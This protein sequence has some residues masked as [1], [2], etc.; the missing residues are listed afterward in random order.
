MR[1]PPGLPPRLPPLG[2]SARL[3]ALLLGG[4][5]LTLLLIGGLLFWRVRDFGDAQARQLALG[6]LSLIARSAQAEGDAPTRLYAAYQDLAATALASG[7]WGVLVLAAPSADCPDA[8]GRPSA[9]CYTDTAPHP[10][11]PA[12]ALAAARELGTGQWRAP[13]GET[14]HLLTLPGAL[15]A[16]LASRG[17]VGGR[18]ALGVTGSYALLAAGALALLALLGAR[19]L[20]VGLRPLRDMAARARTLGAGDLARR[21][22]LPRAQDEV[23]SLA[24]SLNQML[25]RLQEAFSRLEAEEARTRTF[26]ADASHELRT[27]LAAMQGSLEILERL[28]LDESDAARDTRTRLLGTLR[29]E[30]RRAARLV[31]DLLLLSKLDAGEPLRREATDLGELL[32]AEVARSADLAPQVRFEVRAPALSAQADRARVAGALHNLLGNAAAYSPPG[33]TVH[34]ELRREGAWAVLSVR[35][36]AE[37]PPDFLPRLFDR[38]ARGPQA[39][40]GDGGSGLGLATVQATA[41]AHGGDAFAAQEEGELQVGFTLPLAGPLAGEDLAAPPPQGPAS[42][43]G[44]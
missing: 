11:P 20:R 10:A 17:D 22:P 27:P 2:L 35:N 12:G 38:F 44:S 8:A 28:D 7:T 34:A 42:G 25:G 31:N 40:A 29:R 39:R 16:G 18:L 23:A 4:V 41:R 21:L 24:G 37:L 13:G 43:R 14:L 33:T 26:V 19:L 30:T 3:L 5:A 32:R 15:V 36:P 9:L 6:G 1:R